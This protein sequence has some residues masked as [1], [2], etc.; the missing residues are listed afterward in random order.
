MSTFYLSTLPTVSSRQVHLRQLLSLNPAYL[1]LVDRSS[2]DGWQAIS[3]ARSYVLSLLQDT[4]GAWHLI[5]PCPHE[6]DCPLAGGKD[7]CSFSQKLQRP[8][9]TRKTK[10]ANRGEEDVNYT[11]LVIGR[12]PRPSNLDTQAEMGTSTE[13]R[14]TFSAVGR[15]GGVGKE[16]MEKEAVKM[17]GKSELREVEGGEFE[18]VSLAKPVSSHEHKPAMGD[19]AKREE[20]SVMRDEAYG[21]PRVV[22]PPMKRAGHVILDTCFPDGQSS[23]PFSFISSFF[24]NLFAKAKIIETDVSSGNIQRLTYAKSHSKQVYYDARKSAWGDLFPHE[25]KSKL[26]RKRGIRKLIKEEGFTG[27]GLEDGMG[28]DMDDLLSGMENLPVG[29]LES[30]GG[31]DAGAEGEED[32]EVITWKS[33]T[34]R[35]TGSGQNRGFS[36]FSSSG[37]PTV[38]CEYPITLIRG[39]ECLLSLKHHRSNVS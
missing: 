30:T 29:E 38:S 16:A 19:E 28:N 17:E 5:A 7:R 26:V 3:E 10:H 27:V 21:W 2:T 35:S 4:P 12:G 18:M 20:E 36:T 11:Y 25:P 22:A 33:P 23:Y 8:G 34:S 13:E 37:R 39:I 1:I 6:Y 31:R 24:P 14:S 9:F 32:G 15:M